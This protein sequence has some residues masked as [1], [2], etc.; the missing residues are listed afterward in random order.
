VEKAP[1]RWDRNRAVSAIGAIG[2]LGGGLLTPVGAII[3]SP[4][5]FWLGI[6]L[7]ALCEFALVALMVRASRYAAGCAVVTLG[8]GVVIGASGL[9]GGGLLGPAYF[10]FGLICWI[11]VA[12]VAALLTARARLLSMPP[13]VALTAVTAVWLIL[14]PTGLRAD[15]IVVQVTFATYFLSWVWIGTTMFHRALSPNGED[16]AGL[17]AHSR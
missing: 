8:I 3:S 12:A 7:L 9:I 2:G 14:S 5:L 15:H 13:A 10:A 17:C 6:V 1:R 16:A 4:A 11:V